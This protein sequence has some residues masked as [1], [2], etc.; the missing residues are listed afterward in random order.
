ME[1]ASGRWQQAMM[2]DE[3]RTRASLQQKSSDENGAYKC[4]TAT[5]IEMVRIEL[6]ASLLPTLGEQY[7][8]CLWQSARNIRQMRTEPM[9]LI[10]IDSL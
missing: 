2:A 7:E 1:L 10:D 6:G 5:N 9:T 4:Q 8:Q 3:N